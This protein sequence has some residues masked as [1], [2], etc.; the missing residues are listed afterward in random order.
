MTDRQPKA[1][2]Q[3][4]IALNG[5]PLG[6][7]QRA[8][9]AS[10]RVQQRLSLPSQLELT[11]IDT[12][13]VFTS[14]EIL[15]LGSQIQASVISSDVPLFDGQITAVEYIYDPGNLRKIRL[16]GYDRLHLLRKRQSVKAFV[17][18]TL[19]ELINELTGDLSLETHIEEDTPIRAR[20]IQVDQ[21]D[22]DL[23]AE[24]AE[25]NGLY[26]TLRG[27]A[28]HVH[29]LEGIGE[30]VALRLG[31][32]LFEA[33]VE[34]NGNR[35]CRSVATS[36]WNTSR[37]ESFIGLTE[38]E[39]SGRNVGAAIATAK[40]GNRFEWTISDQNIADEME[41]LAVSQAEL[42][43]RI[44]QEVTLWAVAEGDPLL[45]PGTPVNITGVADE[46]NG[47]YILTSV[48]HTIDQDKGFVSEISTS[49]PKPIVQQACAIATYGSVSGLDDPEG[50]GR[51]RVTL[52][53]YENVET[54]WMQVMS[55]GAGLGKGLI[56]LPDIDDTV[57]VLFPRG[58]LTQGV[59]LGGLY[60]SIQREDWDWGIDD[61][62]TKRF[63][64]QTAGGQ[65]IEFND[66]TEALRM[67]NSDGSYVEMSPHK[68]TLHARRDL[69]I[70]A[71]G[72]AIVIKGKT[73]DFEKSEDVD[74]E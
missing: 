3:I 19:L 47:R 7:R 27:E 46:L 9:L 21:T 55:A 64:L 45:R 11:F 18:I 1:I 38:S 16:R 73:I 25:K 60:G 6:L 8:A 43:W 56:A 39:R 67:E 32:S 54:E 61:N 33:R 34:V 15:S 72:R 69:E 30:P 71:P 17:Q 22:F 28:L 51:V 42:D 49:L 35:L 66:V 57:L 74:P 37:V 70:A 24:V 31:H 10:L 62:A 53:S 65:K 13:E 26:F 14:S 68:V 48:D 36:G 59:V 12:G 4:E 23:I 50:M 20:L 41:A 63:R 44:A 5:E 52:P 29:T 2:P 40:F 58:E